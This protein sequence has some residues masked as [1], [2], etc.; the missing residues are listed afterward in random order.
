MPLLTRSTLVSLIVACALLMDGLDSNVI[1]TALPAMAKSFGADPLQLSLG[2]TAYLMSL[3]VFIPVSGWVADRFGARTVFRLAILVFTAGSMLSGLCNNVPELAVA[4]ILQGLG[5]SMMVPVGRLVLLRTVAK[6]D[7]LRAMAYLTIPAQIGPLL[8]PPVGG[9]I[10]TYLSWRWIFFLNLPFGILGFILVSKFIENHREEDVPPLDAKGFALTA[11]ALPSLLYGFELFSRGAARGP[12]LVALF[13][14]GGLFGWLAIRHSRR[15]PAPLLDLSLLRIPTFNVTFWGGVWFRFGVGAVPFLL[16]LMLQV[17]FG[18]S[19]FASGM[20]T[21]TAAI[22]ALAMRL[23]TGPVLKRWGFRPVLIAN[24]AISAAS[25]AAMGL[26][27]PSTPAWVMLAVLLAGGFFRTLQFT[28][29]N[30]VAF[31]DVP[32]PRMSAATSFYSMMQQASL[33]TGVGIAAVT[34]GAIAG[35]RGGDAAHLLPG[36]FTLAFVIVGLI[37]LVSVR[38]Y[39]TLVPDAGAEVSG[40]H[41]PAARDQAAAGD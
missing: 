8:G 34:L 40:H 41:A 30:T 1:A 14:I 25:L 6:C 22:G 7:L 33:G 12:I 13:V 29:L 2:I 10:T 37:S 28:A 17:G 31:A 32:S 19:A 39:A 11:V 27:S 35:W 9:L 18:E 20:M 16:P 5:G 36:D 38:S 4:R 3:A 24:G 23:T 26:F 21:F 15:H